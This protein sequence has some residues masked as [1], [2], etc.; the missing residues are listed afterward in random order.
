M[1]LLYAQGLNEELPMLEAVD[2]ALLPMQEAECG[3]PCVGIW[4][5]LNDL[6]EDMIGVC[7]QESTALEGL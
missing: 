1:E 3:L 5:D 4:D 2:I 6:L 7:Y